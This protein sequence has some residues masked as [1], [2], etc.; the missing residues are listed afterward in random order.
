LSIAIIT[1]GGTITQVLGG[2]EL[3][4]LDGAELLS[5]L[6]PEA[7]DMPAVE[8]DD[9]MDLPSTYVG[10]DEMLRIAEAV[11]RQLD[12]D[13]IQGV[14][15][16]HGT[17]TIEETI[18]FVDLVVETVKPVVFTG[19]QRFPGTDGYDGHRNLRD[20]ITVAST[21]SLASTGVM[22]VFDGEIHTARDVVEFHPTSTAGF[23]SL[24]A[25]PIGR[26]DLDRVVLTRMPLRDGAI[27]QPRT[28]LARVDMLTCYAGMPG[29][30]V[31]AVGALGCAGLVVNGMTSGAVPP[32]V[33]PALQDLI[34]NGTV[35]VLSTRCPSGRVVRRAGATYDRVAGYGTD[36]ERLGIALTDLPGLKARCRLLVLLSSGLTPAIVHQLMD[37]AA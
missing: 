7:E 35:V 26:V 32:A 30:V 16:T 6:S 1:T 20:A 13:D 3:R 21:P 5:G 22:L 29:D 28:P 9:L 18:Y 31:H 33:V 25:G 36:L 37:T 19:A 8:V 24:D 17:A 23:R 11:R 34:N 15:V 27:H 2:S 12:R 14:V 10:P 4:H